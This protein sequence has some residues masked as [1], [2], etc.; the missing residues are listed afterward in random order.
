MHLTAAARGEHRAPVTSALASSVLSAALYAASFPPLSLFPLA[1][2]ALV[3]LLVAVVRVSPPRA[4]SCGLLWGVLVCAGT[5]WWFPGM[6]SE[7][8]AIP[9]WAGFVGFV[10]AATALVGLHTALFAGWLAW[11]ARRRPATPLVVAAAGGASEYVR[12]ELSAGIPW[13]F[14]GYTQAAL[15]AVMQVADLAG[16]Y[17]IGML[18][19]A[20]NGVV[21]GWFSARLRGARPWLSLAGVVAAVCAVVTYGSWRL[22]QSFTEG[23]PVVSVAIVQGGIERRTRW[24]P[25]QREANLAHYLE[26]S[27]EAA[28]GRPAIIFWPEFA[29]DFYLQEATPTQRRVL[30]AGRESGADLIIGGPHYGAGDEQVVYQ[31][32]VFLVR[33]GQIAGRYDKRMPLAVSETSFFGLRS[34]L[35]QV[36]YSPGE[37]ATLLEARPLTL[38]V[39]VCSEAMNP[40]FVRRQ[41]LAGAELLAN[42]SNDYWFGSES[43]ARHQLQVAAVRAIENRRFLVRPTATGYSAVVDPHGKTVVHGRFGTAEVLAATVVPSRATTPYHRVGNAACWLALLVVGIAT[44]RA[45]A[46]RPGE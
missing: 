36:S 38:A 13:A 45:A 22:A 10:I 43:A 31:N 33:D 24:D 5:A 29:I 32:S 2:I 18:L 17:G 41:A 4:A 40:D 34:R 19:A 9:H 37:H 35:G 11:L 1:W 25:A 26:L 44:V 12:L 3:P 7:Y 28:A 23:D 30:A 39:S 46:T 15:P 8:L 21:A 20:A 27:T 16:P 42:P 6:L 14:L